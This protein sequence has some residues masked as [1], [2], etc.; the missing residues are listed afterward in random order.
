VKE[1]AMSRKILRIVATLVVLVLV[2]AGLGA[3]FLRFLRPRSRP[4]VVEVV[5]RTP[6]RLARGKY[7]A[8]H[9]MPCFHCHSNH[10]ITRFDMP[11]VGGAGAGGFVF[12]R[13]LGLPG[14]VQP[15]NI[16]QDRETG[17]GAHTD[18]EIMRAIREGIGRDG[19]PLFPMMPYKVFAAMS[20][21][22]LRALVVYLRAMAPV[23][24][25]TRPIELDFPVSLFIRAVPAPIDAPVS[26]PDPNDTVAYGGYLV[27]M[28]DCHGCHTP[29]DD[30]GQSLAGRD[31]AGGRVFAL[32][33]KDG[34]LGPR[35]VT[36]NIT[37]ASTGYFGHTP[38]EA[39]IARVK[40]Y[41]SIA[42]ERPLVASGTNTLMPW[43]EFSGLS[44][45]DLGAIYEYMKTLPPIENVVN[46]FPDAP[47]E[48]SR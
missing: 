22:D 1:N 42:E 41:A 4:A 37:P 43:V 28:A 7:L 18:G 14:V 26:A 16:T 10:D 27:R 24:N 9:L 47:K 8:E 17:I 31:F 36:A 48:A 19:R 29:I 32:S 3:S 44:E 2:I 25:Q 6:E 20:D 39:W 21:E 13:T 30:R 35:V 45:R 40:S 34:R 46:S 12:D 15:P 5:E 33:W 11:I 38:K 23:R